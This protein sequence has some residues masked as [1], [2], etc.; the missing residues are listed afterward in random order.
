[1][2]NFM[3]GLSVK[4]RGLSASALKFAACIF[5]FIDHS[6]FLLFPENRFMRIL[7]RIAFPIFAFFVAEGCHYTK[8][9]KKHIALIF[10]CGVIFD[11]V[12][13]LFSGIF[14]GNIFLTFSLSCLLIFSL[15]EVKKRLF[16][17]SKPSEKIL[18]FIA[19]AA[20][21]FAVYITC[22]FYK[23]DY[24]F[25]GVMTPVWVSV[26]DFDKTLAPEKLKKINILPVKL[27]LLS[28][29]LIL[30]ILFEETVSYQFFSFLSLL[31]LIFYNNE[32]GFIKSKYFF[33]IFY[34]LHLI[35]LAAVSEFL[36]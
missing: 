3:S 24:G 11:T 18:F 20:E 16:S 9:L 13:Y 15:A 12:Y 17:S 2:E 28:L 36:I 27:L 35:I 30:I 4:R 22:Y 25:F 23:V 32:K 14:Y 21:V 1:M 29:G 31:F 8:D 10:S 33:Y 5:M 7:G 26:F 6:G 19:F 34:P